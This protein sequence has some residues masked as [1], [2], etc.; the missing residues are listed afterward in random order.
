MTSFQT[1]SVV[2]LTLLLLTAS[3]LQAEQKTFSAR[4][5]A[6]ED[7]DTLLLNING[8]QQRIQL[9][10]IDAP[11]DIDNPKLQSDLTRSGLDRERLLSL[12]H[13][14][15]EHLR[16][17]TRNDSAYTLQYDPAQR[18]RY[19]RLIGDVINHQG[20]SLLTLMVT[21]GYAIVSVRAADAQQ[22]AQLMPLQKAAIEMKQ[23][24]WGLDNEAARLWAGIS[25][26]D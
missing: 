1:H 8:E 26:I 18:D 24:L 11:E 7:G 21:Q 3:A 9:K 19:G 13:R 22:L 10:G 17:L 23:G 5:I 20:E 6:L 25:A 16:S 2:L 15:T 12:G 4:D 14:A